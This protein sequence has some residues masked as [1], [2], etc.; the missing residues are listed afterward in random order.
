MNVLVIIFQIGPDAVH[1]LAAGSFRE[2]YHFLAAHSQHS[3]ANLPALN[4]VLSL[5][6]SEFA[7]GTAAASASQTSLTSR[8]NPSIFFC[9][10][11]SYAAEIQLHHLVLDVISSNS[12]IL[13]QLPTTLSTNFYEME[14]E[15]GRKALNAAHDMADL[16]RSVMFM[17]SVQDTSGLLADRTSNDPRNRRSSIVSSVYAD[18]NLAVG[19]PIITHSPT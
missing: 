18:P 15:A 9:M 17:T 19:E 13:H 12:H 5:E 14:H 7:L 11:I 8:S 4:S 6:P 2:T 3:K 16:L 10:L 1:R